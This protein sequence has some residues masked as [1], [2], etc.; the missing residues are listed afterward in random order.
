MA[1]LNQDPS[2]DWQ[3]N[4]AE[5]RLRSFHLFRSRQWADCSFTFETEGG[6]A[7][8]VGDSLKAHKL[9]LAMASPVFA[10]MFYGDVGEKESPVMIN[11]IDMLTFDILLMY[12]YT[13]KVY[14][15]NIEA[16]IN[17]YKAANKYILVHLDQQCLDYLSKMLNPKNVCQIYEFSRF[18]G[19]DLLEE[20]CIKMLTT[21]TQYV[22]KDPSF[23]NADVKTLQKIVS[24]DT[25]DIDSEI[26]LYDALLH[27]VDNYKKDDIQFGEDDIQKSNKG[28]GNEISIKVPPLNSSFNNLNAARQ[29]LQGILE[30][31]RFLSMSPG[32]LAKVSESNELMSVDEIQALFTNK[33]LPDSSISMP[34]GF[35]TLR[36]PRFRG[37]ATIRHTINNVTSI[38]PNVKRISDPVVVCNLS[39]QLSM[40]RYQELTEPL[41]DFLSVYLECYTDNFSCYAK[42]EACLLSTEYNKEY[43]K[44]CSKVQKFDSNKQSWGWPKVIK[45]NDLINP[46]NNF[47]KDDSITL[48]MHF[49]T[50]SPLK[51]DK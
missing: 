22:L 36:E 29:I 9:I 8:Q 13:D 26:D 37:A 48:E 50:T 24:L 32:E 4:Y 14:I 27:Y 31:I 20:K 28:N 17:L 1:L 51:V 30:E 12:I 11:D 7:G 38:K 49:S 15:K 18:F 10:A 47:V 25:L 2:E 5:I 6:G 16:A 23:L 41:E 21:K 19:E 3:V 43:K 33:F 42:L 34:V 45:W 46:E 40:C 35:S 44:H 39:W